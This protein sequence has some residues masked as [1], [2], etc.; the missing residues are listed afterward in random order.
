[1]SADPIFDVHPRCARPAPRC[2]ICGRA[3]QALGGGWICGDTTDDHREL[4][5]ALHD[6]SPSSRA[7]WIAGEGWSEPESLE[8]G[9]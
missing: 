1:M 5:A 3:L 6:G 9:R 7:E 2:G 4:E 8:R